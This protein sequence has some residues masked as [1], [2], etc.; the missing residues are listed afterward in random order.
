[1]R[2]ILFFIILAAIIASVFYLS[3]YVN[4]SRIFSP[5]RLSYA[6]EYFDKT[7]DCAAC[8]TKGMRLDNGKCLDCHTNIENTLF[9]GSGYHAQAS[10]KNMVCSDC[11]SEHHGR[12][13][14]IAYLDR[15]TFDHRET[16]WALLGQHTVLKCEA[17]HKKDSFLL[18]NKMCVDCHRDIHLG[19]LEGN[20]EHCHNTNS[21]KMESYRHKHSEMSPKGKHSS[22]ACDECHRQSK[23]GHDAGFG[24]AVK[25]KN[26]D[27]QCHSCHEDVHDGEYGTDCY[28][29]HN[30]ETFEVE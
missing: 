1:M 29:C 8:H 22:L 18:D 9:Q 5:G 20:C 27:F 13:N 19:Q 3:V 16:G 21:F 2:K 25:Y 4:W 12:D 17:C 23:I 6:H 28:E 10:K 7:G 15:E 24:M 14:D 11:H 26:I 30:Q